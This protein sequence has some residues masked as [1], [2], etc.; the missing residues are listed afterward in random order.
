[1]KLA[2][3][4]TKDMSLVG[5]DRAG[6][7]NR[8]I[9]LYQRLVSKGHD[10]SFI[11]YGNIEDLIYIDQL[12]DIKI[13]CNKWGL[14]KYIYNKYIHII[15]RKHLKSCDI[16]K[17]N[18]IFGADIALKSAKYYKKPIAV[19]LGY[20][21]SDGYKIEFGVKS[22]KY[23]DSIISE[24]SIFKDSQ[25]VITTT[26][27]ISSIIAKY[28]VD[29]H[30]INVIPNFVNCDL[31]KNNSI[32]EKEYDIIYI[33]RIAQEKNINNLLEAIKKSNLRTLIIGNG[34]LKKD[35]MNSFEKKGNQIKWIDKVP[36][37][38][39]PKYMNK[40]KLFV[41]P[42]LYEGHSKVLI[43]AMSCAMTVIASNVQGNNEII[44]HGENG[45]LCEPSVLSIK[46][47]IFDVL[48]MSEKKMNLININARRFV[49]D[50]YSLDKIVTMEMQL[51]KDIMNENN[52]VNL[53]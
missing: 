31:F 12:G 26:D 15:H 33:G 40:S 32:D 46:E 3:F 52:S 51:Y 23:K 6:I 42:S 5:W 18:Q 44:N 16:I 35:L 4:F 20:L 10:I 47:T 25:M 49:K 21:P 53:A 39:I 8:E 45:F 43:E 9:T 30:K 28:D 34:P 36:N 1:M 29:I 7:L 14:P 27:R 41:L 38:E 48:K 13:L 50:N 17:T 37:D 2:L 11:T 22:Q 24:K 19:R